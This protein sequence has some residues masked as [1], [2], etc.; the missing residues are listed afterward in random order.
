MNDTRQEALEDLGQRLARQ[1]YGL[2]VVSFFAEHG[3]AV[4]APPAEPTVTPG[5]TLI[6]RAVYL[7][8]T[9]QG[10]EARVTRHGGPHWTRQ[11]NSIAE[12]EVAALEALQ[13]TEVP[14]GPAWRSDEGWP[15]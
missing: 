12:L 6:G 9:A 4:I 13:T 1:G 14:P 2:R 8:T 11:A 3:L 15:D 7:H 10:W 5:I